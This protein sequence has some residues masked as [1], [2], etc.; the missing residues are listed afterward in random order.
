MKSMQK[1]AQPPSRVK[2]DKGPLVQI[3]LPSVAK[4]SDG[5]GLEGGQARKGGFKKGGFK[6]AFGAAPDDAQATAK[7]EVDVVMGEP[8]ERVAQDND[9]DLTDQEDYY[10]PKKPTG[11]PPSC[12]SFTG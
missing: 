3:K 4:T 10:D 9:S 1:Q 6:S 5:G 8:I 12:K 11:C 7:A 2:D